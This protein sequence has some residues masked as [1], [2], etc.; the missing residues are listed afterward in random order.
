MFLL[1]K[2]CLKYFQFYQRSRDASH[3]RHIRKGRG[4][5]RRGLRGAQHQDPE[6]G[7]TQPEGHQPVGYRFP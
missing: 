1:L 4:G 6:A 2:C 3:P 5:G 7:H